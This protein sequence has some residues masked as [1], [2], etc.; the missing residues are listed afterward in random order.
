[1]SEGAALRKIGNVGQDVVNTLQ[2]EMNQGVVL[3]NATNRNIGSNQLKN[4]MAPLVTAFKEALSQMT[5][6]MDDVTMGKF[7]EK[8]VAKAIYS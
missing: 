7:V 5:V 6:E 3:R 4:N 2:N 1:M 8:T